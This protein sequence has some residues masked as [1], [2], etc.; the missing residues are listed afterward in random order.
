MPRLPASALPRL[1][2]Q[3]AAPRIQREEVAKEVERRVL[4]HPVHPVLTSIPGDGIR[5]AARLVIDVA[6]RAF[7]SAAHLAAY[8]GLAPVTRRSASS[9]PGEQP[10]RCE[11]K[12]LKR[13]LFLSALAALR[14][15]VS[16]AY[17]T[18]K[19]P[20]KASQPILYR[21]PSLRCL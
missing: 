1:V 14:H 9:I 11:N 5:T 18:R 4:T 3:L 21:A 13:A 7:A 6:S 12:Q 19:M 2:Q 17:F 15:P 8:A 16:R 20:G 10:S